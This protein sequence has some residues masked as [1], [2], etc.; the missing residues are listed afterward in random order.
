MADRLEL[1]LTGCLA[2]PQSQFS[3]LSIHLWPACRFIEHFDALGRFLGLENRTARYFTGSYQL[4]T[5]SAKVVIEKRHHFQCLRGIWSND[6]M[7]RLA[8][9]SQNRPIGAGEKPEPTI[10]KT[11]MGSFGDF[12]ARRFIQSFDQI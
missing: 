11:P 2:E 4:P 7:N 10:V 1:F 6:W 9:K 12:S 5:V 3:K 8:E